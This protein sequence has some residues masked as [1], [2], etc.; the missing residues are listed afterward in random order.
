MVAKGEVLPV[1][2]AFV[3]HL[4]T[5]L[6]AGNNLGYEFDAMAIG[7][8]GEADERSPCRLEATVFGASK[9]GQFCDGLDIRVLC[10]NGSACSRYADASPA[11]NG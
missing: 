2:P 9:S 6:L 4:S 8:V 1:D 5:S 7:E 10:S 11:G 3:L